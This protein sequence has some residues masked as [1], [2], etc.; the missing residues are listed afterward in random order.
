MGFLVL[1][2]QQGQKLKDLSEGRKK[3]H[4]HIWKGGTSDIIFAILPKND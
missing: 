4:I 3:A 1:S 2:D